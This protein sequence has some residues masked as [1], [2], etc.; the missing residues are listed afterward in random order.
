MVSRYPHSRSWQT[1]R[2]LFLRLPPASACRSGGIWCSSDCRGGTAPRPYGFPGSV[3]ACRIQ[4]PDEGLLLA[5]SLGDIGKLH[6]P[7]GGKLRFFQ[8]LRDQRKELLSFGGQ[9]NLLSFFLDQ[10]GVEQLFDNIGRV[11]TVPRPPVSV[12]ALR[13]LESLD[14][15]YCSGFS[16]ALNRV[17]S[18][19]LGGGVVLP[20]V[21]VI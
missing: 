7:T 4:Y 13:S 3:P 18:V 19:N 11:A 16:M 5:F 21:S 8:V 12:R 1:R 20:E 10:E 17:A 9:K 15:I 2:R 6:L 14:S